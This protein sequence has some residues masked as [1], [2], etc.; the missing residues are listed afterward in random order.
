MTV[1]TSNCDEHG[2]HAVCTKDVGKDEDETD[3]HNSRMMYCTIEET[4]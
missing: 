3:D 1:G 2:K 4:S